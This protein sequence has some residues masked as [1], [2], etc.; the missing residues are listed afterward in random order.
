MHV[1]GDHCRRPSVRAKEPIRAPW[2][3]IYLNIDQWYSWCGTVKLSRLGGLALGKQMAGMSLPVTKSPYAGYR[4]P[5]G[6][7][8]DAVGGIYF[9]F[10]LSRRKVEERPAARGI[11]V[12]HESVRQ[13]A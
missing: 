3:V 8:S 12:S 1:L 2:N 13:W 7:I 9:R 11:V 4:F 5:A 10:P 6:I